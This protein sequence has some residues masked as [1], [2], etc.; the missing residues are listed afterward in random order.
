MGRG[1]KSL[2]DTG[3]RYMKDMRD[4]GQAESGNII[5]AANQADSY[6]IF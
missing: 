5:Q 2:W 1:G 6:V 3:S 4:L